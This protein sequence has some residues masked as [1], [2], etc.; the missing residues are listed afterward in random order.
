MGFFDGDGYR[1]KPKKPTLNLSLPPQVFGIDSKM[2]VLFLQ[3]LALVL[4]L[5]VSL[6]LVV[7]PAWE[8]IDQLR[9]DLDKLAS[10]KAKIIEK[11]NYLLSVD[12][13]ELA[14][15]S[16]ALD[17]ALLDEDNAYLLVGVVRQVAEKHGFRVVSF[18]VSI[19]EIKKEEGAVETVKM[20]AVS[21]PVQIAL[22]GPSDNFLDLIDSLESGLPVVSIN[23]MEVKKGELATVELNLSAYYI[24][25]EKKVNVDK[26]SLTD[27]T[28]TKDE[29][30]VV[31]TIAS[32]AENG[33][34]VET[35]FGNQQS[36][37]KP[38]PVR[39][40]FFLSN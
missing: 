21:L 24:P 22:L 8:N 23:N 6:I 32:F 17:R 40:P 38:Y 5:L 4:F 7:K 9:I 26:L 1:M 11:Q 2:L 14:A 19:G 31:G 25:E 18:S 13:E 10:D 36:G 15:N 35:Y 33:N 39:N 12:E 34:V 16:Q 27:L 3:P 20:D 29:A 37:F 28:L 30:E